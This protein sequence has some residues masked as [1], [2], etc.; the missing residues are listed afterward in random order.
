[1]TPTAMAT[2]AAQISPVLDIAQALGAIRPVLLRY[3]LLQ[4]RN[5]AQAQDVVQD[6]LMVALEKPQSFAGRSQLQTWLVGI[7]KH[8][9]I[10][11]FRKTKREV[12]LGTTEDDNDFDAFENL[13]YAQDGHLNSKP[14]AWASPEGTLQ[15]KQF[16]AVLEACVSKLPAQQGRVFMMREWLELPTADI[17]K[18]LGLTATN[19]WVVLHRARARLQ[20]CL[21]QSWTLPDAKIQKN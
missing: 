9:I 21:N 6:T 20:E 13:M 16:F 4:L 12:Q 8:K 5:E 11:Q 14:P 15:E 10:D 7:L 17:C 2:S 18:E 19:L 3:A 1:M